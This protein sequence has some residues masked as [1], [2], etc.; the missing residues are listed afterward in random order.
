VERYGDGEGRGMTDRE[1]NNEA[2]PG[3]K[4]QEIK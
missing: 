1:K 2:Y 3:M 4:Q